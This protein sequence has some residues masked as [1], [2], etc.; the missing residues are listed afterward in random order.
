MRRG[1]ME[2]EG[3]SEEAP[4]DA[5]GNRIPASLRASV[6]HTNHLLFVVLAAP[7]KMT[8]V[9]KIKVRGTPSIAVPHVLM[10][11]AM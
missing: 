6:S 5:A 7:V 11:C 3:E 8:T 10:C 4:D 9:Q 2:T 1:R